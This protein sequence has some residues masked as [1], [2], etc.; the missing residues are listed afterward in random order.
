MCF[1]LTF[2]FN[3]LHSDI[4][5]RTTTGWCRSVAVGWSRVPTK[6]RVLELSTLE[7][8][9]GNLTRSSNP[10]AGWL[11]VEWVL[12]N[13]TVLVVECLCTMD[14]A[15]NHRLCHALRC[16]FWD[17]VW[18]IV[19]R[20]SMWVLPFRTRPCHLRKHKHVWFRTPCVY[21]CRVFLG[22]TVLLGL[23]PDIRVTSSVG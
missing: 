14:S 15:T 12:P 2:D 23:K 11:P 6:C 4:R 9:Y 22:F 20:M 8:N 17:S 19:C 7:P 21:M 18:H 16:S 3:V 5:T 10:T 1:I 13:G